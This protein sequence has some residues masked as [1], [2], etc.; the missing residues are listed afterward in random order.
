MKTGT[1]YKRNDGWYFHA[2]SKTTDGVYVATQPYIKLDIDA[3][4]DALG[5]AVL[6]ALA[7][8]IEQVP[9]PT[10]KEGEK[11]FDPVLNLAGV[12]TWAAFSRDATSADFRS[13][14]QWLTLEPWKNAGAKAGFVPIAGTAVRIPIDS[15]TTDIGEALKDAMALCTQ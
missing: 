9:H 4:A 1:A 13:D 8:S 15:S 6:D 11:L 3:H 14:D 2:F 5:Q 7:W 10:P 12:K